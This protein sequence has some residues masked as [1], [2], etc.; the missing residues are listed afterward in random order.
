[1]S[2]YHYFQHVADPGK[3]KRKLDAEDARRVVRMKQ[4]RGLG[5]SAIA[6]WFTRNGKP[7][8][9]QAVRNAFHRANAA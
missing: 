8:S 6:A 5:W 4:Q 2:R 1:M 3:F 9:Y 7:V